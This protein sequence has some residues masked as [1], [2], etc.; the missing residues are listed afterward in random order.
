M[1]SSPTILVCQAQY[2]SCSNLLLFLKGA[3]HS[4]APGP[5][6]FPASSAWGS[7]PTDILRAYILISFRFLLKDHVVRPFLCEIS[8]PS[9]IFSIPFPS[10]ISHFILLF[11]HSLLHFSLPIFVSPLEY[12][13]HGSRIFVCFVHRNSPDTQRMSKQ[14][15]SVP[16]SLPGP[17]TPL[18]RS[19]V[20]PCIRSNWWWMLK[21]HVHP[22]EHEECQSNA[23]AYYYH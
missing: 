6:H 1:A 22:E 12:S 10:Y 16:L 15:L 14:H 2:F 13:L 9:F 21:K 17:R 8:A 7:L 20:F 4:S 18:F 19:G 23:K 11:V 5:L 3:R